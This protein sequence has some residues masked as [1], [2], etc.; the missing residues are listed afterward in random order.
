M[1]SFDASIISFLNSFAHR[2]WFFDNLMFLLSENYLLKGGVIVAL[3]WWTWFRTQVITA[4]ARRYLLC[5]MIASLLSIAVARSLANELPYRERPLRDPAAHF[6]LP[7]GIRQ[8]T[9]IN[10][11]SFPSDHAAVFFCAR[12]LHLFRLAVRRLSCIC[13]RPHRYLF[14]AY[15]SRHPLSHRPARGRIDRNLDCLAFANHVGAQFCMPTCRSLAGAIARQLLCL[16]IY[17]DVPDRNH[18]RP[19]SRHRAFHSRTF[20]YRLTPRLHRSV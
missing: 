19:P 7:Y 1:N 20:A 13:T 14:P 18:L 16:S 15:V 12:N 5:G 6:Q 10:W 17:P 11:S 2:S 3:I 4:Q 9:L 8:D